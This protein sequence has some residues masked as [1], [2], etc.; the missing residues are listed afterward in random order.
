[1]LI[2]C[3]RM[4]FD[5][6]VVFWCAC[7]W[8]WVCVN[9]ME[10]QLN[11]TKSTHL[12]DLTIE[13]TMNI[14]VACATI[15]ELGDTFRIKWVTCLR[16]ESHRNVY[17]YQ[18]INDFRW[19]GIFRIYCV[20]ADKISICFCSLGCLFFGVY[21]VIAIQIRIVMINTAADERTNRKGK[22]RQEI[23]S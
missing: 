9:S 4:A 3:K 10:F 13:M 17:I 20:N 7:V 16:F 19:R 18:K 22:S 5:S 14:Q 11:S 21:S 8:G 1:M 6:Y 15:D 12:I 2:P 23:E